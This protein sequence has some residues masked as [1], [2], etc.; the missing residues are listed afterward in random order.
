MTVSYGSTTLTD[1]NGVISNDEIY[2]TVDY[3]GGVVTLR[4]LGSA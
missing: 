1:V 4:A 2:G 3:D